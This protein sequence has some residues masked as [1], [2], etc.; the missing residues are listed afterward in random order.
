MEGLWGAE[1]VLCG[2]GQ[3]S[4]VFS[5][6]LKNFFP[7]AFLFISAAKPCTTLLCCGSSSTKQACRRG[8]DTVKPTRCSY[9]T[10]GEEK[11]LY[12][13]S[14]ECAGGSYFCLMCMAR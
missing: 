9:V 7:E 2:S 10:G 13:V 5:R 14:L 1:V 4:C 12:R 11:E 3:F 8:M 6:S